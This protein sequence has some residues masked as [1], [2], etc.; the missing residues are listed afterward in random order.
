MVGKVF[1]FMVFRLLENTFA[2]QKIEFSYFYSSPFKT[3]PL[4]L[5]I[6]SQ[7]EQKYSS[8][9]AEI[10]RKSVFPQQK[11]GRVRKL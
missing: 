6:I 5:N 2:R 3:L 11:G 9:Q 10:F 1:R 8:F 4:V 7:A